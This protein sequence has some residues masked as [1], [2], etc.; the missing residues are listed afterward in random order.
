MKR[1]IQKEAKKRI[2]RYRSNQKF[3]MISAALSVLVVM[4]TVGGL[5]LPAQTLTRKT[6]VL[7]CQYATHTHTETCY[8]SEKHLVCGYADYVVHQHDDSCYQD[9]KLVCTLPEI[10]E[11]KHT[12]ACYQEQQE[13]TCGMEESAE[14]QHDANCYETVKELTCGQQELHTHTADCYDEN[15]QLT[16]GLMQL[17]QHQHGNACFKTVE[18]EEPQAEQNEPAP[19][20]AVTAQP[21]ANTNERNAPAETP[22]ASAPATAETPTASAPTQNTEQQETP[23]AVAMPAQQFDGSTDAVTVH[24][25]APEGALPEGTT[26]TVTKVTEKNVIDSVTDAV[27]GKVKAVEAVD[28]TFRNASGQEIEPAKEIRVTMTSKQ[29]AKAEESVV[30]HVDDEG[31]AEVVEQEEKQPAKNAVAFDTNAFS[32]YALAYT[33]DFEYEVDGKTYNYSMQGGSAIGLKELLPMLGAVKDDT[34]TEKNEVDAFVSDIADVRFSDESLIKV[35]HVD[36]DTTVGALKD[37]L[38]LDIQYS[39]KLKETDIEKLNAKELKAVDWALISLKAFDTEEYMTVTMKTGEVF[40]ITVTDDQENPYGLDGKA[41]AITAYK[42]SNST[43]YFISSDGTGISSSNNNCL[44]AYNFNPSSGGTPQGSSWTFEWTGEGKKYL[45]HDNQNRYIVIEND[46]VIL[47]DKDTALDNP[48]T[49]VSREGKYSFVNEKN[50]HALNIF[51]NSGFGSWTYS[52]GNSDFL[53]TLQN[54]SNMKTPGTIDTADTSGL[55]QINLFDY[56]PENEL[57]KEAR[58]NSNPYS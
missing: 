30:V 5:I 11:H 25:E 39:S 28:I 4:G 52:E 17:E 10:P 13:L 43:Y 35:A 50:N 48:I 26:M 41:F 3:R 46:R 36:E 40:Q 55:L 54:P 20:E 37:K 6:Q 38:G 57:D 47:T 22:T 23:A 44:K 53:M 31:K 8:D 58:N 56:G 29:I 49:V 15:G 32:V 34:A 12:D 19:A 45:I 33:V 9:G 24:A 1:M 14:H 2:S 51:G 27:N 21:E 42:N 7:D 16:C 18:Q